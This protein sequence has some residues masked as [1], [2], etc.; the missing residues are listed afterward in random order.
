LDNHSVNG[1]KQFPETPFFQLGW[2]ISAS[3]GNTVALLDNKLIQSSG[4]IPLN[5][6]TEVL[7]AR[8]VPVPLCQ[9]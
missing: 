3:S 1:D 4:G 2:N 5:E 6:E 8:P 7:G 9:S